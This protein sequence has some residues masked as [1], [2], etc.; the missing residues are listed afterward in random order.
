MA[1]NPD[2]V[3]RP[4]LLRR[5]ST[6]ERGMVTPRP[7]VRIAGSSPAVESTWVGSRMA[8]IVP[9][10]NS[11]KAQRSDHSGPM[12]AKPM[13]SGAEMAAANVPVSEIRAFA[14]TKVSASGRTRGTAAARV[15]L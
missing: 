11:T 13:A 2:I 15:T 3:R 1:R 9:A 8:T 14:L 12:A 10:T 4:T 5:P 6:T 7:V